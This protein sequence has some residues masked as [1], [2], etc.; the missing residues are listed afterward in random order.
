MGC[1]IAIYQDKIIS[2][3]LSTST[4]LT[5]RVMI[6]DT[7][8]WA[9]GELLAEEIEDLPNG[10]TRTASPEQIIQALTRYRDNE[11]AEADSRKLPE[12]AFTKDELDEI[13]DCIKSL[14]EVEDNP[15]QNAAVNV[16]Y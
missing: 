13:D 8:S 4:T 3:D 7:K 14:K 5:E 12:D 2:E 16:W 9:L 1:D 10:Y 15:E 6:M 11:K